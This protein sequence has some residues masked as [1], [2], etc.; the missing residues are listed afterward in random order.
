MSVI[1]VTFAAK[2]CG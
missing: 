1:N 2:W